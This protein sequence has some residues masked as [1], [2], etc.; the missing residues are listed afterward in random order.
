MSGPDPQQWTLRGLSQAIR[1]RQL[2]PLEVV[3]ACLNR[4]EEHDG[5]I[6]AFITVLHKRALADARKAE[7]DILKGRYLGPLHGIPYGVKDLFL[8]KGVRT[9]C[10]SKI[11]ADF[12]PRE[13]A[14]LVERLTRAGAVLVGKLNMHEFAFG[15]TSVNPHYGA[16]RNPWD[17]TRIAGGSSGG[18]AAAV[19]A[20]FVMLALGTDTG[21]SIRIPSALCGVAGL[22]PTYGRLSRRGV[23]PLAWSLDHPGPLTKNVADLALAMDVLID[24]SATG[25]TTRTK[26]VGLSALRTDLEGLRIGVPDEYYFDRLNPC[27]AKEVGRAIGALTSLGAS[28][29]P[30]SIPL[31]REAAAAATI[32]LF[33][34]AAS[35]LEKWHR[36]RAADLGP[37]VR[38]RL[39]L[40]AATTAA[41]YLKASRIRRRIRQVFADVFR[42][43]DA[44]VTPQLP[45]TAPMI[46]ED[47]IHVGRMT[48]AVPDALTR[49]TRISN[50]VGIPS[51]SVACGASHR[52]PIGLQISAAA[53]DERTIL[54]IGHAYERSTKS[55]R[56][57]RPDLGNQAHEMT[58]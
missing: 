49:L 54:R 26:A 47:Q 44:L 37:D 18:S 56:S 52:M 16:V 25:H 9:T 58:L 55:E 23:Y 39:D 38:A 45:I 15:T 31:L 1:K 5:A 28:V 42:S 12:I 27:V 57:R 29:M 20:S 19:A 2:S 22:K 53:F 41:Q 46:G 50:L 13:D 33:A 24:E 21:G 7:A 43:V 35:S 30:I 3:R 14:A 11:L 4:I 36:T 51:L 40:G 10:G 17:T 6:N 8:T 48:E 34:E 32:T